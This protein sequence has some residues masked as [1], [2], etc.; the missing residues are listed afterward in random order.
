MTG[1]R[2]LFKHCRHKDH[3]NQMQNRCNLLQT[4]IPVT[5]SAIHFSNV[6]VSHFHTS[7]LF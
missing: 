1:I 4:M 6:P 3:T 5:I 2:N 7:S